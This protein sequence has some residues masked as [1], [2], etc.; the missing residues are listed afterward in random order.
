MRFWV[1][2]LVSSR[3]RYRAFAVT[4][5]MSVVLLAA[6]CGG[7]GRP[8]AVRA[9][10][11]PYTSAMVKRCLEQDGVSVD[12]TGRKFPLPLSASTASQLVSQLQI[13]EFTLPTAPPR[14]TDKVT[15]LFYDNPAAAATAMKRLLVSEEAIV[16]RQPARERS[17]LRALLKGS[18]EQRQNVTIG[19]A[20][21]GGTPHSE[22]LV[23]GC[24]RP[25]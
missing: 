1:L 23:A 8:R 9:A 19:W 13:L 3:G 6:G 21:F 20:N 15:L 18:W 24:L 7:S 4:L 17:K 10:K 11:V 14:P 25:Q 5:G 22:R 12:S 16:Q 2:T